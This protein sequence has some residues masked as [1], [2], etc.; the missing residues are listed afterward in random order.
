MS[1]LETLQCT[2]IAV[3]FIAALLTTV[4]GVCWDGWLSKFGNE[5]CVGS[6]Q[7]THATARSL[8]HNGEAEL[9]SITSDA[10]CNYIAGL[11][12]VTHL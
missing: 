2:V 6:E 10:D 8:C 11:M 1:L 9:A 4:D 5:Y 12:L 3:R 7:V